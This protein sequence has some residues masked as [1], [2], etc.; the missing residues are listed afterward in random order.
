MGTQAI[1][2][3]TEQAQALARNGGAVEA[4][5]LLEAGIAQGD[6]EAAITL[7]GWR[8]AGDPIRRDLAVAR[9]LFGRAVELGFDEIEP[10]YIALLANGAGGAERRWNEAMERQFARAGRDPRAR[11]EQEL[12]SKMLIDS[13]GDPTSLPAAKTIH[14]FPPIRTH[15]DFLSADECRFL[16]DIAQPALRP[17]T[18]GD[19]RTGQQILDPVRRASCTG[20]PFV[21]ESPFIHAINRRIALATGTSY[22][23]GEP[24][25]IISYEPG[26]EFKL[27][28]DAVT[29]EDNQRIVTFLV[30]LETHYTGGETAF[31]RIDLKF[32]TVLGTALT[33]VNVDALGKPEPL[34]WHAGL[35]VKTGRKIILS[36]WIRERPL[37]LSGPPGKPL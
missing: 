2:N 37:D 14:R 1:P 35:P 8:L 15:P 34:A 32:R 27:H 25:Q 13:E 30:A 7:A 36:K 22:E 6:G 31:P 16:C 23:Q 33:F 3:V 29:H 9:E 5:E 21:A 12:L 10:I 4:V 17:A 19:P 24:L 28:S 11:R 26:E 18:V 20:F